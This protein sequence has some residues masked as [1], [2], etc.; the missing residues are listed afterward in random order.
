[1]RDMIR[2]A[3]RRPLAAWLAAGVVGLVPPPVPTTAT[4]P[5][6]PTVPAGAPAP[7]A[8]ALRPPWNGLEFVARKL[9]LTATASFE[10]TIE[11]TP[12]ASADLRA[13]PDG[14]GLSP[15][16]P[17]VAVLTFASDL[18]I[19]RDERATAWLE[20]VSGAVL[21]VDKH[22]VRRGLYRKIFRYTRDGYVLWRSEPANAQEADGDI[23]KWSRRKT[24]TVDGRADLPAGAVVTDSYALLYILGRAG[25]DVPGA[26][27]VAYMLGDR[28]TAVVTLVA[29]GLT[30]RDIDLELSWPGGGTARRGQAIVRTVTATASPL[31]GAVSGHE[32]DLG[33]LGIRGALTIAVDTASGLPVELAGRAPQIGTITAT[34]TRAVLPTA[35]RP[36]RETQSSAGRTP[37]R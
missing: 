24:G 28:G 32:I 25:L 14:T 22:T 21:Q 20:P 13:A 11:P 37:P 19:G 10:V 34:L 15:A 12:V 33:F 3:A 8:D 7:C 18:P 27:T 29:G 6:D 16:G 36:A 2:I 9:F 1:M 30:M 26:R 31:G 35:P 5:H 4:A 23:E 17:C